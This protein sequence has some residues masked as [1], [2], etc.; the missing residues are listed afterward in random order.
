MTITAISNSADENIEVYPNPF[1][2]QVE[3]SYYSD[4]HDEIKLLLVNSEG[5]VV[6]EARNKIVPGR[7][8]FQIS[9]KERG[10]YSLV[11]V[12]I[13]TI[14]VHKLICIG[15]GAGTN[16]IEYMA[17]NALNRS[18]DTGQKSNEEE[19]ASSRLANTNNECDLIHIYVY[20]GENITKIADTPC[21]SKTYDVVFYA[22]KDLD[23]KNYPI[24]EIGNQ[25]W[26]AENLDYKSE[27]SIWQYSSDTINYGKLYSWNEAISVCPSGWHL[28]LDN[29]WEQLAIYINDQNGPFQK[30]G[31]DWFGIGEFL[32]TRSGWYAKDQINKNGNDYYGFSAQPAGLGYPDGSISRIGGNG[33]LWSAENISVRAWYRSLFNSSSKYIRSSIE[34]EG[35]AS[36]R[37]IKD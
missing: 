26:M 24:V 20:S 29:E 1:E 3:L 9:V 11:I 33:C 37:C 34:K 17:V 25:W 22:C 36:V 12:G 31:D 21:A 14:T 28:P 30:N 13:K 32:K 15:K 4:K 27:N 10:F 23:G 7:H 6:K 18:N 8:S 2:D 5:K 35:G 16:N 19:T